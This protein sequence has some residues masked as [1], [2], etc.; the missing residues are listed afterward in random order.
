LTKKK[1]AIA[2]AGPGGLLLAE[3]LAK[4]GMEVT[5]FE[6]LPEDAHEKKCPWS[7][8]VSLHVLQAAG[9][10]V[11]VAKGSGFAGDGVKGFGADLYESR[12]VSEVGV[13]GP[14]YRHK[15][16]NDAE[17]QVVLA[18][19]RALG[20]LQVRRAL[21]AGANIRYGCKAVDMTGNKGPALSDIN[22][23]GLVIQGPGGR[24][25]ISCDLVVDAAGD[26][27]PLRSLLG[28]PEIGGTPLSP[29]SVYRTVQRLESSFT[30]TACPE[31]SLPVRHHLCLGPR[32]PELRAYMYD[33]TH[34]DLSAFGMTAETAKQRALAYIENLPCGH[35][36]LSETVAPDPRS[37]PPPAPVA[38][39]FLAL[40]GAAAQV[41]PADPWGIAAAYRAVLIAARVIGEAEKADLEGLWE[42][43]WRWMSDQG[44]HFSALLQRKRDFSEEDLS[45]LLDRGIISAESCTLD[46][47]GYFVPWGAE[48]ELRMEAAYDEKP[49]LVKD[50]FKHEALCRHTL[51]HYQAYPSRYT[52]YGFAR[53]QANV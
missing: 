47:L 5:V 1:I 51:A 28:A 27:A 35:E 17:H 50:L 43:A 26:T 52:P 14:D 40:G 12:R 4:N 49:D 20:K 23:Q 22:I 48:D 29:G 7:D 25:E 16:V 9:L 37:A 36:T 45:Y 30:S 38:T 39:G 2:G 15:T 21:A 33:D 8:P 44:A 10:P 34:I 13:Y 11:P 46:F 42:Y 31:G 41:N 18:D 53:W 3:E 6:V 32:G 19:R 24:E